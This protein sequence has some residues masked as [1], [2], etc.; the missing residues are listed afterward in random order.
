[1]AYG[2]FSDLSSFSRD[3]DSAVVVSVI[4]DVF[5]LIFI[6]WMQSCLAL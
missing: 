3:L 1:M 2:L 4:M 5:G 6:S